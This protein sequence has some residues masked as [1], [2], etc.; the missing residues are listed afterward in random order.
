MALGA[1]LQL[2]LSKKYEPSTLVYLSFRGKDVAVRTNGEGNPVVAFVG[3][4]NSDGKIK[5]QR[6]AR[7]LILDPEGRVIKSHWDLKGKV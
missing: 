4:L 2:K 1:D 5:G 7:T 6:Y 3:I